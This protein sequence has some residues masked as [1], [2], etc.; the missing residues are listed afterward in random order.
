MDDPIGAENSFLALL[1]VDP[2]YR[3][4]P[5]DPIELV[6]LSRQYITTPI[7][8]YALK[9][10]GNISTVTVLNQN[11]VEAN[12]IDISYRPRGGFNLQGAFDLH[13]NKVVSLMIEAELSSWS[14]N[15]EF[16]AFDSTDR[17]TLGSKRTSL[18]ASLPV[19]IRLTY[20]RGKDV[21]VY[22]RRL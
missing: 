13:F 2:E 6:Y 18:Q 7:T 19:A 14:F 22:L 4:S 17:Q 12:P 21:P 11:S 20:P 10:G 15:K 5:N 1:A 8:S 9:L 16:T 3:V